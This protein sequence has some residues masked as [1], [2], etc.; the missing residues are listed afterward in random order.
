[1]HVIR[2]RVKA[3]FPSVL[4]TLLSIVQALALELLWAHLHE[5]EYLYAWSWF[6]L[7]AWGQ[8]VGT[9]AALILIWVV[10]AGN[11]MRFRWVPSIG[12][13]VVPF[14]IG[15][16]EFMMIDALSPNHLGYWLIYLGIV[17]AAM[18][19]TSQATM[20]RARQ[21]PDNQVYFNQMPPAQIRDFIPEMTLVAAF[22]GV[23]LYI[24]LDQNTGWLAM[25]ALIFSNGIL[26]WRFY[27]TAVFWNNSV[28]EDDPPT[29]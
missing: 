22:A 26:L 24:L 15:L 18:V 17:Y 12:D 8:I 3:H 19:W 11:A 29:N 20:R 2:E 7:L 1:M 6:A 4:L 5:A 28:R 13:S 10:Y 27:G 25:L 23:G 21:D 14:A 9:L 16:L